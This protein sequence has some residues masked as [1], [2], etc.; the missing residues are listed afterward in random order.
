M[1]TAATG[2]APLPHEIRGTSLDEQGWML[3]DAA[4]RAVISPFRTR[5]HAEAWQEEF[6]LEGF[7]AEPVR[8]GDAPNLCGSPAGRAR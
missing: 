7:E 1:Q 6:C 3:H 5:E 8:R 4:Y 2:R